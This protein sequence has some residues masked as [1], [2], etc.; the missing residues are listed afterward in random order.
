MELI[1]N[2][3]KDE[4]ITIACA[5]EL[6]SDIYSDETQSEFGADEESATDCDMLANTVR[7]MINHE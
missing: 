6:A 4:L 7:E 5:L 3:T 1:Q 2:F